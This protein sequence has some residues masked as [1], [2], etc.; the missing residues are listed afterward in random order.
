MRRR[1]SAFGAMREVQR[2]V[3]G[4]DIL[5]LAKPE[6]GRGTVYPAGRA[7]DFEEISDWRL[8]EQDEAG[9]M[10][11]GKF[12][13][14]LFIAERGLKSE[15]VENFGKCGGVGKRK[16]DLL[17]NFVLAGDGLVLKCQQ[18]MRPGPA[19]TQQ[20]AVG[21]QRGLGRVEDLIRFE[22][23]AALDDETVAAQEAAS[24]SHVADANFDFDFI[25]GL[26]GTR[27]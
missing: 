16:L 3:A 12:G 17:P 22:H 13:A 8:I 25:S 9:I 24:R 23:A 7:F 14:V 27:H 2:R 18:H 6:H 4:S 21:A 20:A 15:P 5:L 11:P 1:N 26:S 10:R 19:Q